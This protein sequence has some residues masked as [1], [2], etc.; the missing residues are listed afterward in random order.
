[1]RAV[2]WVALAMASV[3]CDPPPVAVTDT[4][5]VDG[6]AA[7]G[8]GTFERVF[9]PRIEFDLWTDYLAL[10]AVVEHGSCRFID[11]MVAD[12]ST[13]WPPF[14]VFWVI[15]DDPADVEDGVAVQDVFFD[16][17]RLEVDGFGRV[18]GRDPLGFLYVDPLQRAFLDIESVRR[19]DGGAT[20]QAVLDPPIAA[21]LRVEA[22]PTTTAEGQPSCE[23]R[24]G[25]CPADAGCSEQDFDPLGAVW[26]DLTPFYLVDEVRFLAPGEPLP[27]L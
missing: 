24:T 26:L 20:L 16:G 15:Y 8:L 4:A 23:V 11:P 5:Q 12:D 17:D 22:T 6:A 27:D 9:L 3:A 13:A 10:T 21:E 1:M 25:W 7:E 2:P 18:A 14:Q 19:L